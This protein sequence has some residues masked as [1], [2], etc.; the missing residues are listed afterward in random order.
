MVSCRCSHA[1]ALL[2]RRRCTL[3]LTYLLGL[4]SFICRCVGDYTTLPGNQDGVVTG[5][6]RPVFGL[7][8]WP[9]GGGAGVSAAAAPP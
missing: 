6:L 7:P 4:A 1:R 9:G 2:L 3:S 5:Q 8:Q